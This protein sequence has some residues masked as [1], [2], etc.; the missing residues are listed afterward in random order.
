MKGKYIAAIVIAIAILSVSVFVLTSSTGKATST[1]SNNLVNIPANNNDLNVFTGKITGATIK[2][3]RLEGLSQTDKGCYSV[4]TNLVECNT[5][6]DTADGSINFKY[7]HNMGIQPCLSMFG[8][9][10]VIVDILDS[11]GNAK[12]TRTIDVSKMKMH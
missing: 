10:K 11:E 2:M 8:P 9:E 5:D 1:S 3:G 7:R 6:I 4:G 12:I